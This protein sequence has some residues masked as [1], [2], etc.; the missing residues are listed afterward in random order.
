MEVNIA[1]DEKQRLHLL[2]EIGSARR[3]GTVFPAGLRIYVGT[4]IIEDR[5]EFGEGF[6]DRGAAAD[7]DRHLGEI[8]RSSASRSCSS[9]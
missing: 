7:P 3:D 6:H 8:C 2:G 4:A 9:L 1:F 5:I